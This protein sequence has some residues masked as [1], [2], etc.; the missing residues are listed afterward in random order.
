MMSMRVIPGIS[1]FPATITTVASRNKRG[2]MP[3]AG[4]DRTISPELERWY[5]KR[6]KSYTVEVAECEPVRR[7]L[8]P[9]VADVIEGAAQ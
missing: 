3:V 2:W 6:A 7:R 5:A 4:T 9:Q 8:P 1:Q